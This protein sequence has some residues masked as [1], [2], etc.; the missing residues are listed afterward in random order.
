MLVFELTGSAIDLA[1]ASAAGLLPYL[2]F[3]LLIGTW[4][5]RVDRKRLMVITDLSR[6][7]MFT[8]FP[9]LAL[10]SLLNIYWIYLFAFTSSILSTCFDAANFAAVPML[11]P[12]EELVSANGRIQAGFSL[13]YILG[14]LLAPL[15]ITIGPLPILFWIDA[16]SF[17]V[18]A[19]LLILI[20]INFNADD[21]KE[22]PPTSIRAD[23]IEGMTYILKHP[24]LFWLTLML[25]FANLVVP[26]IYVQFV[27]FAKQILHASDAQVGLLYAASSIGAILIALAAGPL[28]KRSSI[29]IVCLGS[30]MIQGVLTIVLAIT[31]WYWIALIV[32]IFI[33]CTTDLFNINAASLRQ[34][35]VPDQLRGR[36]GSFARVLGRLVD[37]LGSFLG[38]TAIERTKNAPLVYGWFGVF[39]FLIALVF[40]FTPLRHARRSFLKNGAERELV[41]QQSLAE[42]KLG[43]G[44]EREL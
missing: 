29:S 28:S 19:G 40:F 13:A 4:V 3:G 11:V 8:C 15:L 22:R 18:S 25:L 12:E 21:V 42:E 6:A 20:K 9:L 41:S 37:P 36:V 16:A 44:M 33:N 23:I 2:L 43:G 35:L 32:W 10:S 24:V 1:L 14:S 7:L 26:T 38:G 39:T 27:L 17:L 5:D 31:R 34:T 30:L